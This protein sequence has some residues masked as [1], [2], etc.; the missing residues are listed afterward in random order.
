MPVRFFY[1]EEHMTENQGLV[2]EIQ[3][4]SDK[5]MTHRAIILAAMARGKTI[6]N[7]PL[8]AADTKQTIRA[9]QQLGI[10]VTH[11][12]SSV[13]IIVSPGIVAI[14]KMVSSNSLTFDF[15]NSGTTTRLMIG[16][17]AGIGQSAVITGDDS[18]SKRPMDRVVTLLEKYGAKIETHE[19][20][21]PL[22]I[23]Q[24]ITG[25]EI[26]EDL[27]IPSAQV[28]TSL[29]LVGLGA[30]IPV[31]IYDKFGT[32]NHT[33][34]MLPTFGVNVNQQA[35][36]IYIPEN[37]SLHGAKLTIP[38]DA[39]SAAFWLVAG[40]LVSNS[41]ITLRNISINPTRSGALQVLQ[42]MGA[43]IL[44]SN[45][46]KDAGEAFADIV[47]KTAKQL[48]A[49]DIN[50]REMPAL[51]DEV[52]IIA[53]AMSQANGISHVTHAEELRVK[54]SNRIMSVTETLNSF[55]AK[56][57]ANQ[58]GFTISGP[59]SLKVPVKKVSDHDDHRIAMLQEITTLVASDGTTDFKKMDSV[60]ISYP[61]FYEDLKELTHA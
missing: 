14:K 23:K 25:K 32:R 55:G 34:N 61:Q 58:D 3:V 26:R 17:L 30:N 60:K 19:G 57:R 49:T 28:K 4:A 12:Q 41:Q 6:I 21:L 27:Q 37:Q 42:R 50:E 33:E 39:S 24:G 59:A 1:P 5:S 52:P 9:V 35:S 43:D 47:I 2:G 20:K 44:I 56:I 10:S 53:L 29:M 31:I 7:N 40:T 54:E 51:I 22:T 15:G 18:L 48:N 45:Q 13:M 36:M 38:G 8:I 16:L 46:T 11:E